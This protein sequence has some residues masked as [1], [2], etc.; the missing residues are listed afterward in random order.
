MMNSSYLSVD[1]SS[2]KMINL[3]FALRVYSPKRFSYFGHLNDLDSML[4]L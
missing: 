4:D 2:K 3:Y 1:D